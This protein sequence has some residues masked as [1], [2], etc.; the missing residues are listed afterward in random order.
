MMAA[1]RRSSIGRHTRGA[2]TLPHFIGSRC[3]SKPMGSHAAV[4]CKPGG[5]R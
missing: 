3:T 2:N 5:G 1:D 4:V